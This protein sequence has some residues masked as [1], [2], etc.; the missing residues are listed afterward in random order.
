V[1]GVYSA[2]D[3]DYIVTVFGLARL[4]Y[5]PFLLS[6]R[7]P[8]SAVAALLTTVQSASLLYSSSHASLASSVHALL[9]HLV[10]HPIAAREE[11]ENPK[12][13][14]TPPFAREGLVPETEHQR[15][16]VMLHSSGSTG[17]PKPISFSNKRMCVTFL[18][19][20][21][22]RAWLSVPMS[23]AH[24]LVVT[25]QHLWSRATL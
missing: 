21:R 11:Y 3:L 10:C 18:S 23:H 6:P 13:A 7:L 2:S 9:P 22:K 8:A 1:I 25:A 12:H 16:Y 15:R 19:A 20:Q 14:A 17:L 5:V 24:G 4:G